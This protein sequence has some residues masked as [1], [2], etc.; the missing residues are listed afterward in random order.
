M[1]ISKGLTPVKSVE[2]MLGGL[3]DLKNEWEWDE[4][5]RI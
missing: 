2:L 5:S 4:D 3:N 1:I